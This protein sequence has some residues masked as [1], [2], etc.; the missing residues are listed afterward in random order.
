MKR[1]MKIEIALISLLIVGCAAPT[2][3]I[4]FDSEPRG[5]R[6]FLTY[7][8]NE[9]IAED[10][11]G[12]NFLGTTPF[13]WTTEI[14]GDGTFKPK[15]SEIPFYS[16]FVKGVVVFT[17]E[18]SSGSSNLYTRSQTYHINAS[19]QPGTPV[20]EGIFFDLTKKP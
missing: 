6:V 5:A 1:V 18:P 16:D 9:K 10:A 20:P 2:K 17:A 4:S 11:K 14:E 3:T 15:G 13:Q 8:A 7:G 12:R 19:F